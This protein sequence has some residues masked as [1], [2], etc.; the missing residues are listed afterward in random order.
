MVRPFLILWCE[1]LVPSVCCND[2]FAGW[3]NDLSED[4]SNKKEMTK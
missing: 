3:M 1:T 4:N 2:Q